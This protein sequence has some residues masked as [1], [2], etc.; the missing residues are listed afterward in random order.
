MAKVKFLTRGNTESS[1]IYVRFIDGRKTDLS[2]KTRYSI[3]SKYW[4]TKK[5]WI[6]QKAEFKNKLNLANKLE[7]LRKEIIDSH[8]SSEGK[9][10]DRQWLIKIINEFRSEGEEESLLYRDFITRYKDAL[11]DS[12][13]TGAIR[14]YNTSRR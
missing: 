13:S 12:V 10:I 2:S 7:D 8:N 11:G 9:T 1:S 4:S 14:N 3:N 5:N 6:S